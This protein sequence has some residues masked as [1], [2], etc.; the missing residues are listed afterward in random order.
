MALAF[1]ASRPIADKGMTGFLLVTGIAAL[2]YG[3]ATWAIG[4]W[5]LKELRTGP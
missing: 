3:A 1:W 5:R 2:V 4:L